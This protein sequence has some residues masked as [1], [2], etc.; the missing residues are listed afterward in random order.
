[1]Q[2]LGVVSPSLFFSA[3]AVFTRYAF[4]AAHALETTGIGTQEFVSHYHIE[5]ASVRAYAEY[6]YDEYHTMLAGAELVHHGMAGSISAFSSQIAPMSFDE[7]SPWELSAHLQD[8][9]RLVPSVLAELGA[10]ATSFIGRQGNFSAVDPR[11]SLLLSPNDDLHLYSS[12]TAVSQFVHP[13][14]QSGIFLFYPSIFFYPSTVKMR[15]STSLQISLGAEQFLDENRYRVAIESYYRTTQNLHDFVFDTTAGASLEDASILGEENVYGA[16][17]TIDRRTGNF[18]GSVRYSLTW[19]NDQF[20]ELNNG[21][22]F[23]PR[24]DRRH[25]LYASVSYLL[26]ENLAIGAVC[27]LA[28]S[29]FPSFAPAG[30]GAKVLPANLDTRET[31]GPGQALNGEQ[32]DLNGGRLPRFQRLEFRLMHSFGWWGVPFQAE[33]R[34]LNG[35]GLIDPFV[36]ALRRIPDE[37]LKWS[38]GVDPPPLFPLYPVVSVSARF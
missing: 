38:A 36:W 32:Y 19:A 12:L 15:P 20:P 25:E 30:L 7:F 14:R 34:M 18:T 2:W 23:T 17:L 9:W 6:T 5:D 8:Q 16:E 10:R 26:R 24:F 11:L 31:G 28:S 1:M 22:P 21:A 29:Q 35:Y 37:R 13:Y 33:V 27:L 3:S 4:D